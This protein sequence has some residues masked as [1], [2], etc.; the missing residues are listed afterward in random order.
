MSRRNTEQ[1]NSALRIAITYLKLDLVISLTTETMWITKDW[2]QFGNDTIPVSYISKLDGKIYPFDPK[3]RQILSLEF[4][5]EGGMTDYILQ[6]PI[7]P[8]LNFNINLT[9]E[10]MNFMR[11]SFLQIILSYPLTELKRSP[12]HLLPVISNSFWTN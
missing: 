11:V 9:K 8:L 2:Y 12:E 1:L 5:Q 6:N 3:R 4:A 7:H 10:I